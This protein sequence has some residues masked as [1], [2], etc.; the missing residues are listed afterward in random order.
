MIELIMAEFGKNRRNCG[1]MN[2]SS[3]GRLDPTLSTMLKFFPDLKLT[4]YTDHDI[5]IKYKNCE[6]RKVKPL[7]VG[8]PRSNWRSSSYY[9]FYGLSKTT[10]DIAISMDAD[11]KVVSNNIKYIIPLTHK[12]GLCMPLNPRYIVKKDTMIGADSDKKLDETGGFGLSTNAG[13]CSYYSYNKNARKF[14]KML[15]KRR[16]IEGRGTVSFW[17]TTWDMGHEFNPYILP[18]QWCVCREHVGIG[19]EIVLHIGH[20]EVKDYYKN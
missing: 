16:K 12:F 4:I 11:F 18:P 20:K 7:C 9:K 14:L 10:C 2:L 6:I 3:Y 8:H 15:C 5:D 13:F 19:D 17:R 1:N